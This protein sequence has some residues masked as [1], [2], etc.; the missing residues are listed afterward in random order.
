M[1]DDAHK[2]QGISSLQSEMFGCQA[3]SRLAP[4]RSASAAQTPHHSCFGAVG[5][6]QYGCAGSCVRLSFDSGRPTWSCCSSCAPVAAVA[7]RC[8]CSG[9]SPRR[10]KDTQPRRRFSG[11]SFAMARDVSG[12]TS[13]VAATGSGTWD[14]DLPPSAARVTRPRDDLPSAAAP[15]LRAIGCTRRLC[16]GSRACTVT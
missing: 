7:Q 10:P 1:I 16:A 4:C 13:T 6:S 14:L 15:P 8:R 5:L 12:G 2:S 11:P 3:L 9:A